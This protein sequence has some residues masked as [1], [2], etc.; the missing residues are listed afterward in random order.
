MQRKP[1]YQIVDFG[2]SKSDHHI[3]VYDRRRR[4]TVDYTINVKSANKYIKT[5]KEKSSC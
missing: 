3:E 4:H 2:K 1:A 5:E